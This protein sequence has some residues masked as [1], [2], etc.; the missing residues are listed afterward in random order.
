MVRVGDRDRVA[1]SYGLVMCASAMMNNLFVTFYLDLF[2][3]VRQLDSTAF[4]IGQLVFM[5]WNGT[6]DALFGWLSDRVEIFGW[7]VSRQGRRGR[8]ASLVQRRLDIILYGGLLWCLA[9]ILVWLPGPSG[10]V[11]ECLHFALLLCFYDGMLTLVE[12]NH[13]ALLADLSSSGS[14]RARMNAAAAIFAGLGSLSSI[15]G[16][17]YWERE[18]LF[19]FQQ[20]SLVVAILSGLLFYV[21]ATS[22]STYAL[23]PTQSGHQYEPL[24]E[25]PKLSTQEPTSTSDSGPSMFRFLRELASQ[26]N[27]VVFQAVYF[28]QAF[29]CTFGKN[30]FSIFMGQLAGSAYSSHFL[31]VI[32]SLSFVLPWVG[33]VFITPLVQRFGLYVVVGGI[34][35]S[36]LGWSAFAFSFGGS[37]EPAFCVAFILSNR[38]LS[39]MVCRICPLVI[40]DLVDEDKFLRKRDTPMSAS[41]VGAS[42]FFG[43]GSQ[44]L[45][46][47]LGYYVAL[48]DGG[49]ATNQ[50]DRQ[51][52]FRLVTGIPLLCVCVQGAI[53]SSYSLRGKYLKTIKNYALQKSDLDFEAV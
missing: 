48:G 19:A 44:S 5:V 30:H 16:Y 15:W 34:F 26:R 22:L 3:N 13:S 6:N 27:F 9:F 29:D 14:E 39:E 45:A 20:F 28:L 1:I 36:R 50:I 25:E 7:G 23:R 41:I 52:V 21:A 53:W 4:Y 12:V 37:A 10:P 24:G 49:F 31:G 35:L 11:L 38:V 17:Y 18:H 40:T 32:V 8:H 2:A 47:M 42:T 33:T 46:P 51:W 43:K